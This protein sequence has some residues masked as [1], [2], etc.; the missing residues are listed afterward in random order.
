MRFRSENGILT[1]LTCSNH[2][3]TPQK[4]IDRRKLGQETLYQE[5]FYVYFGLRRRQ[6]QNECTR[7]VVVVEKILEFFI[8]NCLSNYYPNPETVKNEFYVKN[9][10]YKLHI[11]DFLT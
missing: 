6:S 8:K 7:V 1:L 4:W 3:E 2:S 10:P 11:L 9:Q 5:F